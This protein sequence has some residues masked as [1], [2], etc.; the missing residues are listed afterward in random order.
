MHPFEPALNISFFIHT[1]ILC[2]HALT[3]NSHLHALTTE[4]SMHESYLEAFFIEVVELSESLFVQQHTLLSIQRFGHVG[5]HL[6][7]GMMLPKRVFLI[8][9]VIFVVV[10]VE[11]VVRVV[12][13]FVEI[14]FVVVFVVVVNHPKVTHDAG[15]SL[16]GWTYPL[17]ST[18]LL[19]SHYKARDA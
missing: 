1:F 12:V 15:V 13:V 8:L 14:V 16:G 6:L 19:T 2:I 7:F 4:P 5:W 18:S 3:T 11:I 9:V 10:I 17:V